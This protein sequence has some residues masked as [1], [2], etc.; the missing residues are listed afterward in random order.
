MLLSIEYKARG[1]L[2][3]RYPRIE[4]CLKCGVCCVVKGHSCHVQYD[5]AQFDPKKTY[6]YNIFSSSEP[7]K[8]PNIWLCV[9]CHKCHE[10]CPYDV[11]PMKVIEA[12]KEEAFEK[13]YSHPLILSEVDQILSTGLAFPITSSTQIKREELGLPAL[14][15][16]A[17]SDITKIAKITG[18][19]RKMFRSKSR[20][21]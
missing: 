16:K 9:S 14:E 20:R 19:T 6:V 10:I 4:K 15:K 1:D 13:G 12:L 7:I 2:F 8:N 18:L 5:S 17:I 3:E 21:G 11:N